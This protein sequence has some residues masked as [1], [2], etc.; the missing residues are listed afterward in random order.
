MEETGKETPKK[1]KKK[2]CRE[3][4]SM[5]LL[6]T[7]IAESCWH[8]LRSQASLPYQSF[9]FFSQLIYSYLISWH[10]PQAPRNS[11]LFQFSQVRPGTQLFSPTNNSVYSSNPASGTQS[12]WLG[13]SSPVN[14]SQRCWSS[15][16]ATLLRNNLVSVLTGT[17]WWLL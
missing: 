8:V 5:L 3:R 6:E 15:E 13:M 10:L 4:R 14:T 16:T 7:I 12:W 2:G 9:P 11:A 1:K 17:L